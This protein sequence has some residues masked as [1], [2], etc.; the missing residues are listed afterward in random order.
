MH[1]G[2]DASADTSA[3]VLRRMEIRAIVSKYDCDDVFNMD[4]TGFS[5]MLEPNRTLATKRLSGKNKQKEQI[6]V[7]L[8]ANATGTIC[9][10]PLIINQYLKLRAS[11]SRKIRYPEN[12]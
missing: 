3:K 12:C 9:F 5:Y 6:T 7:V 1:H 8:T 10:P 4:E 11:T 2:E